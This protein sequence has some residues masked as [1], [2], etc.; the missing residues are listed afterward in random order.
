MVSADLFGM[1]RELSVALA[2]AVEFVRDI[3]FEVRDRHTRVNKELAAHAAVEMVENFYE[4][5]AYREIPREG[6]D[7]YAIIGFE[8]MQAQAL[9]LEVNPITHEHWLDVNMLKLKMVGHRVA[10]RYFGK[11]ADGSVNDCVE[12]FAMGDELAVIFPQ[13]DRNGQRLDMKRLA[14]VF[15]DIL[16]EL[17]PE[18]LHYAKKINSDGKTLR[19]KQYQ[20]TIQE[21]SMMIATDPEALAGR[22]GDRRVWILEQDGVALNIPVLTSLDAI[23]IMSIKNVMGPVDCR[24]CVD[25]QPLALRDPGFMTD[26]EAK[27][28]YLL[29]RINAVLDAD[30]KVKKQTHPNRG[31]YAL[32]PET[33]ELEQV[34][35]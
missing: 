22:P 7:G 27:A 15:R 10:E 12:V 11:G 30:N 6:D 19:R 14:Q 34:G 2:G 20:A 31:I 29:K 13:H 33:G 1:Q 8:A 28:R 24:L 18:L 9:D 23:Q 3:G 16:R 21:K 17:F 4:G 26:R 25:L 32:H 35:L 5:L